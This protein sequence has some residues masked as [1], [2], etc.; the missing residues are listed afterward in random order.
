MSETKVRYEGNAYSFES[1]ILRNE[2]VHM[3]ALLHAVFTRLKTYSST[4]R[5]YGLSVTGITE[6]MLF[7]SQGLRRPV[8]NMR[9]MES[10]AMLFFVR[11]ELGIL[12]RAL[13][14][15]SPAVA[16]KVLAHTSKFHA[17]GAPTKGLASQVSGDGR[18][19]HD[20]VIVIRTSWREPHPGGVGA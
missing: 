5:P 2:E 1:S 4:E 18:R 3:H 15:R 16:A 6:N 13:R 19:T 9:A 12:M 8:L 20:I 7:G 11:R 14:S 10:R 17:Q